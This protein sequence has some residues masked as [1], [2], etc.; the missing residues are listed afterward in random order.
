MNNTCW[1]GGITSILEELADDH[2]FPI[3]VT[4]FLC[5]K[6]LIPPVKFFHPLLEHMLQVRINRC[7]ALTRNILTRLWPS[8]IYCRFVLAVPPLSL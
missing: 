3:A 5:G 2:L 4:E 7:D 1:S 6:D 8:P